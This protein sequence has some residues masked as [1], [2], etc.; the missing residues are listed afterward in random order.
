MEREVERKIQLLDY[1]WR[2]LGLFRQVHRLHHLIKC[3][4]YATML[5][6][7]AAQIKR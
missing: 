4:N 1:M 2:L 5:G 7:L 3:L 6:P